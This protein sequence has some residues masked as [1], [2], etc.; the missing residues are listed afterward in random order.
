MTIVM[1]ENDGNAEEKNSKKIIEDE[2]WYVYDDPE[3][4][5]DKAAVNAQEKYSH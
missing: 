1:I 5:E 2:R 3:D 4:E